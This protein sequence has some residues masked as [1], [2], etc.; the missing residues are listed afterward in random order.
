MRP[1]GDDLAVVVQAYQFDLL[2][3]LGLIV[4]SLATGTDAAGFPLQAKY[5]GLE[6]KHNDSLVADSSLRWT[7]AQNVA[8][9]NEYVQL[10]GP[11]NA[12]AG[13]DGPRLVLYRQAAFPSVRASLL[14]GNPG[15]VGAT[16]AEVFAFSALGNYSCGMQVSTTDLLSVSSANGLGL[17][18]D[19][20]VRFL[21][22]AGG[23]LGG[24]IQATA[25]GQL[26][27]NGN[28]GAI[29]IRTGGVRIEFDDAGIAVNGNIAFYPA[30][31]TISA[32]SYIV[33]PGGLYVS[34]GTLYVAGVIQARS[35]IQ[36]DQ[37]VPV[38]I[39]RDQGGSHVYS[40]QQLQCRSDQS[41]GNQ[42]TGMSFWCVNSGSAP[43]WRSFGPFGDRLDC[44]NSNNSAYAPLQASA[45]NVISTERAKIELAQVDDARLLQLVSSVRT[46]RFRNRVRPVTI[47]P[48]ERFTS[49]AR[50]WEA[51]G[52]KPLTL[53][54]R[55]TFHADHDCEVDN[56][57]GSSADPC[58]ITL[59]DTHRLGLIAEHVHQVAP[60]ITDLDE[61]AAPAA[62]AVD[63]VAAVAF[64]AVGALLRYVQ[65]LE[66]RIGLLETKLAP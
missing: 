46:H 18:S 30:N 63:Q 8:N 34:G 42:Q 62:L 35:T 12:G 39:Y 19:R 7:D 2:D 51:R 15:G 20:A 38:T 5:A 53:T 52:H 27:M 59:N 49:A 16:N 45:F 33:M 28:G 1:D 11:R 9:G 43:I 37:G 10:L 50:R 48:T 24:T 14:S 32:A 66:A 25:A 61:Q 6:M 65:A 56:C 4:A 21:T 47:R 3:P 29:Y 36:N 44:L 23:V 54:S 26:V 57:A 64:G 17:Y 22:G 41:D 13:V 58:P 60:E 55:Y 40:D 31:P